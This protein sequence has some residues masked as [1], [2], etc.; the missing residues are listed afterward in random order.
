MGNRN[1][2]RISTPLRVFQLINLILLFVSNG[3]VLWTWYNIVTSDGDTMFLGHLLIFLFAKTA[4]YLT[5]LILGFRLLMPN[6]DSKGNALVKSM[7][8]FMM[9]VGSMFLVYK[10]TT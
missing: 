4:Y 8:L 10:L 2:L 5:L 6:M 7:L 1:T 3:F 9:N